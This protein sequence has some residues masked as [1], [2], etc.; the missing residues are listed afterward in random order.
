VSPAKAVSA[1]ML[2]MVVLSRFCDNVFVMGDAGPLT[3]K[4]RPAVSPAKAASEKILLGS[5]VDFTVEPPKDSAQMLDMLR[6]KNVS[7]VG[8][9]P[10]GKKMGE[11][12]AG[13]G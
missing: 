10:F 13:R 6:D 5:L 3:G 12:E 4:L 2:C 1:E 9:K 7:L 11:Y 8:L